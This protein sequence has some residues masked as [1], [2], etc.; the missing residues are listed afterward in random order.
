MRFDYAVSW[1]TLV[2]D[3]VQL[4]VWRPLMFPLPPWSHSFPMP[5]VCVNEA[6]LHCI[7]KADDEEPVWGNACFCRGNGVKW[8]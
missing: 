7:S 6:V 4:A 5:V 8:C 2:H 1:A 3:H